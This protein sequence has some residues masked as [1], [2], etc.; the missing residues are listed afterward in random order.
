[1]SN[2]DP[3]VRHRPPVIALGGMDRAGKT[4]QRQ[5]LLAR[6]AAQGHDPVHRWSRVGYTRRIERAKRL[7]RRVRGGRPG[8]GDAPRSYPQRASR[9]RSPWKRR[10]WITVAL[11]DLLWE[12]AVSVR[13]LRARGHAVVCDRWLCD[14]LVDLRVNFPDDRV[15][16]RLLWRLV[17]RVALRPDAS[18]LLLIPPD[19]S[20]RRAH[21]SG[22]RHVEPREVLEA[23]L[24]EYRR[25][26]ATGL[27]A[28]I[29]AARPP[30]AIAA[31]LGERLDAILRGPAPAPDLAAAATKG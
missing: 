10:A 11:L 2:P 27:G 13:R 22:R 5:A 28:A 31:D 17:R 16:E 12:Y 18:F 23:R 3:H 6:L 29:D 26:A 30:E 4:I 8:G 14:A 25:I 15:E 19:E 9:M 7:L 24:V 20:L 1:M 21:A